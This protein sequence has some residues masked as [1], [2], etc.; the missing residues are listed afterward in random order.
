MF[1]IGWTEMLVIAVLAIVV[2]GPKDLP[3]VMRGLA[4]VVAKMRGLA[5]EFQDGMNELARETEIED[6][7]AKV[8]DMT[9][10]DVESA[11]HNVI[12]PQHQLDLDAAVSPS[13]PPDPV[14]L[15][16]PA[17][18]PSDDVSPVTSV[19]QPDLVPAPDEEE[20]AES[21]TDEE[22]PVAPATEKPSPAED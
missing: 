19:P 4:R 15:S 14:E 7:K 20:A 17:S 12:D 16:D 22:T 10:V 5:R 2:I 11:A 9:R 8:A 13:Q 21:H 18:S 6:L 1:D 3:R